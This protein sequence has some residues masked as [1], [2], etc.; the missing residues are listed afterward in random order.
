MVNMV[1]CSN[2]FPRVPYK[3]GGTRES[4]PR[5][6]K[7]TT[8]LPVWEERVEIRH[9]QQ[10]RRTRRRMNRRQKANGCRRTSW[11]QINRTFLFPFSPAHAASV[12]WEGPGELSDTTNEESKKQRREDA[13]QFRFRPM[14]ETLCNWP[15]TT[16]PPYMSSQQVPC[17]KKMHFSSRFLCPPPSPPIWW[18]S[19]FAFARHLVE[20]YKAELEFGI[21]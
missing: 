21:Q 11:Q 8:M 3:S 19:K 17:S 14:P 12:T 18:S 13:Y 6:A 16:P 4:G 5:N 7:R 2:E 9:A 1:S 20:V 15:I 10:P